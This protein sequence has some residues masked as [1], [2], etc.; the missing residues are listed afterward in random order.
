[1]TFNNDPA[2]VIP[3]NRGLDTDV[4]YGPVLNPVHVHGRK[5]YTVRDD[6]LTLLGDQVYRGDGEPAADLI[7]VLGVRL[8]TNGTAHLSCIK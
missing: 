5:V 6:E 1:M 3:L 4:C 8:Q 2:A 7:A